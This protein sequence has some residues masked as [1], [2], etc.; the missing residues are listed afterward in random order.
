MHFAGN[1]IVVNGRQVGI[2]QG[3]IRQS[4][5]GQYGNVRWATSL[6]GASHQRRHRGGCDFLPPRFHGSYLN[7]HYGFLPDALVD[8]TGGVVTGINL[9]SFSSDLVMMVKTAAKTGSLMTCGTL[10]TVSR[11]FTLGGAFPHPGTSSHQPIQL[12]RG[13]AKQ[14]SQSTETM[15]DGILTAGPPSERAVAEFT[16]RRRKWAQRS[17]VKCPPSHSQQVAKQGPGAAA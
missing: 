10:A 8:L 9:H 17:Q 1:T 12:V 6:P 5:A 14:M 11:L 15:L 7:L 3:Q 13:M 4:F 2:V 16:Y